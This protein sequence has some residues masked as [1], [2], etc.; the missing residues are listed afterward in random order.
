VLRL[1]GARGVSGGRRIRQKVVREV[2]RT[3]FTAG[4]GQ[5][6]W[7]PEYRSWD[8]REEVTMSER[9]RKSEDERET[10]EGSKQLSEFERKGI[11][12]APR[13]DIPP[14]IDPPSPVESTES[15]PDG[16]GE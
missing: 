3:K 7:I 6:Y 14:E 12:V 13:A 9:E 4:S 10:P 8:R 16:T 5:H 2:K 15:P 1:L 11:E